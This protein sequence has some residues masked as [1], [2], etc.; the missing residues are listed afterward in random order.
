MS[1]PLTHADWAAF[2][3]ARRLADEY[4]C[5]AET[6]P[7]TATSLRRCATA[8]TLHRRADRAMIVALRRIGRERRLPLP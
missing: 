2:H 4:R 1:T 8:S 3:R 7:G 5:R 6:V